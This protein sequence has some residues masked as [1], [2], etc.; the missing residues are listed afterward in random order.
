VAHPADVKVPDILEHSTGVD[1]TVKH[2]EANAKVMEPVVVVLSVYVPPLLAV[3]VPVVT[4]DPVA[5][6]FAHPR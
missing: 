3:H 2:D 6:T 4:N 1:E 5:G